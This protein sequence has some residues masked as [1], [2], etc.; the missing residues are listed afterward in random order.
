M[1]SP[2]WSLSITCFKSLEGN[3]LK[4]SKELSL[5]LSPFLFPNGLLRTAILKQRGLQMCKSTCA[6]THASSWLPISVLNC[7]SGSMPYLKLS[8][9]QLLKKNATMGLIEA[10]TTLLMSSFQKAALLFSFT[11][12]QISWQAHMQA[13]PQ[14]SQT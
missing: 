11:L 13:L 3:F 2:A 10:V 6:H 14:K 12:S 7:F 4:S 1:K 5:I 8:A 9:P